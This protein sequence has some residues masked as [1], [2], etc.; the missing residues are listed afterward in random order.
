MKKNGILKLGIVLLIIAGVCGLILGGINQVT[1]EPI[2]IQAKKT[3]D[4]ANKEILPVASTFEEK[5]DVELDEG[6]LSLSEGKEGSE[7]KGYTIKV[8]PKGYGGAIEMMVGISTEGKIT[9][10]KVLNHSETPGLGA[11]ADSPDF[12]DQYKDKPTEK[13]SVVKGTASKDT[14]IAA[15]TGA[16]I[17]SNAV[18]DGVNK[19][20]EFYN[21]KLKGGN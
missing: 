13:L 19:A 21:S 17:T 3:I 8:A 9:G 5:K 6:I 15:I 12:S 16:T 18:T 10:I 7:V 2:A 11:H 14:E 1:A 4:E 20:I